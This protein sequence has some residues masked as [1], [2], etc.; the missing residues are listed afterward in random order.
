VSTP[1]KASEFSA[2]YVPKQV[3]PN[4]NIKVVTPWK[5]P[6]PFAKRRYSPTPEFAPKSSVL[7]SNEKEIRLY[8]SDV[9]SLRESLHTDSQI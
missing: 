5:K 6:N 1:S 7:T 9:D 2:S 8:H 4:K 3:E